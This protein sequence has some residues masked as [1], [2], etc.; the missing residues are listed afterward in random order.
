MSSNDTQS[1]LSRAYELVE[2]GKYEDA[3]A[4]LDPVIAANPDNADAWWVYAHAVNTPEDGRRALENVVRIDP[5]YPGAAELLAQARE[6]APHSPEPSAL[7]PPPISMPEIGEPDTYDFD[8][9]DEPAATRSRSAASPAPAT[10]GRGSGLILAVLALIAVLVVV[11]LLLQSGALTPS[12]TPG[13]TEVGNVVIVPTEAVSGAATDEA[14]TEEVAATRRPTITPTV[15]GAVATAEVSSASDYPGVAEALAA[16]PLADNGITETS[17]TLGNTLLVS[18]CSAPGR[19]MRM[20]LPQVM[21]TLAGQSPSLGENIQ[22]V[23]VSLVNCEAGT[24]MVTVATEMIS[25]QNYAQGD[26]SDAEF[27]ASW[28]P[29]SLT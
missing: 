7:P 23:G 3:R 18:V 29:Q 9:E 25:A 8:D 12:A 10:S 19:E 4:I 21:N 14:G 15:E 16:F 6:L 13:A 26:L 22:A 2:S 5:R 11:I 27:A 1:A 28:E 20:L 24:R 17:T